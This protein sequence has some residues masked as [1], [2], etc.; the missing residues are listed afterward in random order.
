METV[1]IKCPCCGA[2]LAVK[3]QSDLEDKSITCPVCKEKN[4]YKSFKSIITSNNNSNEE[5]TQYPPHAGNNVS[6]EE[7]TKV[8]IDINNSNY[9]LGKLV[10]FGTMQ[11]YPLHVGKNIVGRKASASTADIQLSTGENKRMSR[12]H[13]IIEVKKVPSKGFVHYASLYKQKVNIT[14][15][16]GDKL[17][18]GDCII[19]K[20]GDKLELPDVTLRFEIPDEEGTTL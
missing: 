13:L 18:Y 20:H 12:E 9:T 4:P 11:T 14:S 17:E 19:L 6:G 2:I 16:N 10:L 5:H 1:K 8:N 7:K 3:S 15:I